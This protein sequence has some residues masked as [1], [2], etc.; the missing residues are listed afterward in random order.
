MPLTLAVRD[1]L[2]QGFSSRRILQTL[3]LFWIYKL[4]G[5]TTILSDEYGVICLLAER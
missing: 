2:V 3:H 4:E 5:W 1:G